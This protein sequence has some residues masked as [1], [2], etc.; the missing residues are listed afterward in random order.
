MVKDTF[1]GADG[2]VGG[3]S[4]I[5]YIFCASNFMNK[6]INELPAEWRIDWPGKLM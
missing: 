1:T 4:C 6:E 3:D 2:G 5:F